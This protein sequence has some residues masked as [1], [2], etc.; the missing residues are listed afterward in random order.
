MTFC[1]AADVRHEYVQQR[2]GGRNVIVA[3]GQRS[4]RHKGVCMN[5]PTD[6]IA[7]QRAGDSP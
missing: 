4:A 1:S 6:S 7:S 3:F 2:A 5:V